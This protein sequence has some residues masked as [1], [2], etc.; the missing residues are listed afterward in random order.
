MQ[1]CSGDHHEP[2]FYRCPYVSEVSGFKAAQIAS[3]LLSPL[4]FDALSRRCERDRAVT[5]SPLYARLLRVVRLPRR[6]ATPQIVDAHGPGVPMP[7]LQDGQLVLQGVRCM[8][9][10][11]SGTELLT[12]GSDGYVFVWDLRNGELGHVVRTMQVWPLYVGLCVGVRA[13]C[14]HV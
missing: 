3:C 6:P 11:S 8:A 10:R 5:I 9:V 4:H 13:L 7:S 2:R 14:R 1:L 12:A